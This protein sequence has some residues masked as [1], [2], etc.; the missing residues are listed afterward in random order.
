MRGF[1]EI[2]EDSYEDTIEYLHKIKLL[3]CKLMK[4]LT[5]QAES[6]EDLPLPVRAGDLY[7]PVHDRILRL[8]HCRYFQRFDGAA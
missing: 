6:G 5:E 2:K 4:T 7:R 8:D 1:I 3:A